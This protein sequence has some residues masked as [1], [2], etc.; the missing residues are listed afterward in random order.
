MPTCGRRDKSRTSDSKL[1]RARVSSSVARHTL[2]PPQWL[3]TQIGAGANGIL[4][5]HERFRIDA[6]RLGRA[7]LPL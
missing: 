6:L 7:A 4:A 3:I 1:T 2:T 5:D